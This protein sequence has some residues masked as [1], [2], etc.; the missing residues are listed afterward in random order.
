MLPQ[1]W[2]HMGFLN[3]L[4]FLSNHLIHFPDLPKSHW[5][6]PYVMPLV[7]M[8][9]LPAGAT[10]EPEEKVSASEFTD[11]L[12]KAFG[13]NAPHIPNLTPNSPLSLSAALEVLEQ[14]LGAP[15]ASAEAAG[16]STLLRTTLE[17]AVGKSALDPSGTLTRA[18]AAVQVKAALGADNREAQG[19]GDAAARSRQR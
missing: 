5:A 6:Y 12:Q 17:H 19:A 4:N 2:Q 13:P 3:P 14:A 8:G 11:M 1:G 7:R 18:E 16:K 10:F 15:G 9:V